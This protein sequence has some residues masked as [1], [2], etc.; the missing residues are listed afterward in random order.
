VGASHPSPL[1]FE[2]LWVSR[3]SRGASIGYLVVDA[4]RI[5][6]VSAV[7]PSGSWATRA[8]PSWGVGGCATL[9]RY[10]SPR[11]SPGGLASF[12]ARFATRP[13]VW[14]S[15]GAWLGGSSCGTSWG[16]LHA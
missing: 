15:S 6:Q 11:L 13:S 12:A 10:S 2:T 5:S 3:L 9:F 14:V 1:L 16:G 8:S 4:R 7:L